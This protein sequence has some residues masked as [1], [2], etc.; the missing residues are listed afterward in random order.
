MSQAGLLELAKQ[1]NPQAIATLMNHQLQPKGILVKTNLVQ[2]CLQIIFEAI[3]V[4]PQ[5]SLATYTYNAISKL[6][7]RSIEKLILYGKQTGNDFFIWQQEFDF[8]SVESFN[9][10]QQ[11]I[12]KSTDIQPVVYQAPIVVQPVVVQS[13]IVQPAVQDKIQIN[14]PKCGSTQVNANKK[15]FDIGQALVGGVLTGGIGLAAGFWGSNEIRLNCLKCGH[16]WQ[17]KR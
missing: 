13:V 11:K 8:L 14:C 7:S 3:E 10:K 4:P 12:E 5:Q 2:S 6:D 9:D 17:P 1:G 16:R 15:G